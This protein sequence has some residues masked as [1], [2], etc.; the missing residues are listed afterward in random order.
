MI[1]QHLNIQVDTIRRNLDQLIITKMFS[2]SKKKKKSF[3]F[4]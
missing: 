2:Y 4:V 3:K 1:N